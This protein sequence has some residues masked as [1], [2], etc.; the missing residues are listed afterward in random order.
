[1]TNLKE[2]LKAGKLKEFAR[3][4]ARDPAGD[5]EKLDATLR[6]MAGKS[7]ATRGASTS[8]DGERSSDTQTR[9]RTSK[10]ASS[11]R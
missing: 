4:H 9:R 1:M 2:A 3:K 7:K 8:A 11:K 10:G 6:S 5:Q